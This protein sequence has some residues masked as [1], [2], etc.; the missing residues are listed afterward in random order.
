MLDGQQA[1]PDE[2]SPQGPSAIE[3]AER[4]LVRRIA[5]RSLPAFDALY[6]DY[7]ARL[8]RFLER[9]TLRAVPVD[10]LINDTMLVVW[11]RAATYNGQCKVSTWVFAIAYRKALKAL[12]GVDEPVADDGAHL[13][14]SDEAG[15]EEQR[16][17]REL[18]AA[19]LRAFDGLSADQRAVV[20]LTYFHGADYREIAQIVDC[21]VATVKT[22]MFHARR[23]LRALLSGSLED[24]L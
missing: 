6:R 13:R 23:R 1:W 4:C 5:E 10:E 20:D 22:R 15:P 7:H 8:A 2:T 19:L 18:R 3:L 11:N 9:V 16:G 12:K 14:P 17:Q 24:W 21:P